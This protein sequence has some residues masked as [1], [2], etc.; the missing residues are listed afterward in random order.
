LT[1]ELTD[2]A[3]ERLARE[4]YDPV[5]GARPLKRAFQKLVIDPLAVAILEGRFQPGDTVHVSEQD[6]ELV[7]SATG[8]PAEAV[9]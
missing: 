9:H 3:K 1:L 7:M 6:G 2:A 4:G 5:F 8:E